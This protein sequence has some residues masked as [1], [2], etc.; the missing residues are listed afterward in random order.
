MFAHGFQVTSAL[1]TALV[2]AP[3]G[4]TSG[5][6]SLIAGV[7]T[8][9]VV[10]LLAL[11]LGIFIY[12]KKRLEA[13]KREEAQKKDARSLLDGEDFDD[14]Y[15]PPSGHMQQRIPLGAFPSTYTAQSSI[16]A[17]S[18]THSPLK[19]RVT[20]SG[21]IFHE[22][23]WPPPQSG[24]GLHDPIIARSSQVNLSSVVDDVMGSPRAGALHPHGYIRNR[25]STVDTNASGTSRYSVV[26]T[27]SGAA[28][29]EPGLRRSPSPPYTDPFAPSRTSVYYGENP[30]SLGATSGAENSSTID[31]TSRRVSS[32]TQ[33]HT[34]PLLP[35][36]TSRPTSLAKSQQDD[37][38][39]WLTRTLKGWKPS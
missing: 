33:Q 37:S 10:I 30:P 15:S 29:M 23:I 9:G 20:D 32:P 16:Y 39:I 24:G 27:A 34:S 5:R 1:P 18:P 22:E 7:T 19:T 38:S 36:G 14:D 13:R 35:G 31:R 11:L 3:K 2:A 6:T 12:A 25:E 26:S 8:A 17:S 4:S 21:S 28:L